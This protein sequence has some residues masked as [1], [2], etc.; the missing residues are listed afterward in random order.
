M[1]FLAVIELNVLI[2]RFFNW[3]VF[4]LS[5]FGLFL[6]LHLDSARELFKKRRWSGSSKKSIFFAELLFLVEFSC[7]PDLY[8]LYYRQKKLP[9]NNLTSYCVG[10]VPPAIK[11]D[12]SDSWLQWLMPL[13]T[14]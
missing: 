12:G 2:S 1:I 8:T 3:S 10:I 7:T 13:K 4:S 6:L 9:E 14:I 5:V 11:L